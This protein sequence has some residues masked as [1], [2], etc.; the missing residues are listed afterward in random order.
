V[1]PRQYQ[2]YEIVRKLGEGA[3]GVVYLAYDRLLLRSVV[4]KKLRRRLASYERQRARI[5]REARLASAI[6]H[7]N[8]CAIYEIHDGP[9]DVFIVMQYVAGRPLAELLADGRL[10]VPFATSIALQICEGLAA[11]HALDVVHRDLKP[12]NI[13]VSEAGLVKILDFGLARRGPGQGH[14][15]PHDGISLQ[16]SS[17]PEGAVGYMAP[18]QFDGSPATPQTDI[19]AVGVNM[20]TMLTGAHPFAI[21]GIATQ[22]LARASQFRDPPPLSAARPELPAELTRLVAKAL[23]KDPAERYQ[24]AAELR[25]ALATFLDRAP[26]EGPPRAPRRVASAPDPASRPSGLWSMLRAFVAGPRSAP[27]PGRVVVLPFEA[28]ADEESGPSYGFALANAVATKLARLPGLSLRPTP[29]QLAMRELPADPAEAGERLEVS[30]VIAGSYSSGA[31]RFA[32]AWQLVRVADQSM[33]AGDTL[34]LSSIDMVE[35]QTTIS[36]QVVAAL[37]GAVHIPMAGPTSQ[38][39]SPPP[40]V[41][42]EY[43]EARALLSTFMLRSRR[44][45]DVDAARA[46]LRAVA[47]RAPA[48]APVHAALGIAHLQYARN[49][50]GT[51]DDLQRAAE[52]FEHALERDPNHVEAKIFRVYT[53]TS[54]G[55]K[56]S[57]RHA[58]GHL[59]ELAPADSSVRLAAATLLRMDG[60][61]DAALRQLAINLRFNPDDAHIVYNHR[62]RLLHYRHDLDGA[63]RE[64]Q[65]GL[66]LQPRHPL[67]RATDGYLRLREGDI[68]GAI[69]VLETLVQDDPSLQVAYPTLAIARWRAGDHDAARGLISERTLATA[70]CDGDTAYRVATFHAVSEQPGPALRWL[71]RAIHL[72]NEN[73]PWFARNPAWSPL[74]DHPDFE[75]LLDRLGSRHRRN[76][77]E[78]QRI[79]PPT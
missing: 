43:F 42:E 6:D 7:P 31:G 1:K 20:Y 45:K 77:D 40:E 44:R 9:G 34:V 46:K 76:L 24:S 11:A 54:L 55:D 51:I 17:G 50:F 37:R 56:A 65:K 26:V 57:A 63:R 12:A 64:V 41:A 68:R 39:A 48:F 47:D 15:A 14:A 52:A 27:P 59:L 21:P 75:S 2:H 60:A 35:L 53:L 38:E 30:Y 19:F 58:V 69:A 3:H 70:D 66:E 79:L 71:R 49:G 5:L 36:D 61:Y 62:A 16:S 18:E 74:R 67:L 13:M 28:D 4:I 33:V 73:A 22:E 25:D 8:V 23:A 78:W 72:G 10:S 29:S 32:V